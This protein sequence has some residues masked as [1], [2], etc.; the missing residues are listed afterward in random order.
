MKITIDET[1]RRQA[2]ELALRLPKWD[3]RFRD[4]LREIAFTPFLHF[5]D[6]DDW[7]ALQRA[8]RE[9]I[10]AAEEEE[11][12]EEGCEDVRRS[13]AARMRSHGVE[14]VVRKR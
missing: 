5:I 12:D 1:M 11:E 14:P 4:A 6:D 2:A 8:A 7:R 10:E 3:D 9:I 13:R